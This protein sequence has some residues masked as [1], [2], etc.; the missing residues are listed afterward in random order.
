[1]SLACFFLAPSC[2]RAEQFPSG[3]EDAGKG[4]S[5]FT[6]TIENTKTDFNG[7]KVSWSQDDEIAIFDGV[8]TSLFRVSSIDGGVATFK[9][10]DGEKELGSSASRYTA[11]YPSSSAGE[12]KPIV[13]SEV[14]DETKQL[15]MGAV[16]QNARL[17]FKN[18]CS[19]I[20]FSV[21]SNS[22][23]VGLQSIRLT[24]DKAL[25]GPF[26]I[27]NGAAVMT[28]EAASS[29]AI[30]SSDSGGFPLASSPTVLYVAVPEGEYSVF[31]IEATS[32]N[33][34]KKVFPLMSEG[35]K[36]KRNTIYSK[37]LVLN[38]LDVND[39][40]EE[41]PANCYIATH[42]GKYRFAAVRGDGSA[43]S[44][45]SK[46]KVLWLYNNTNDGPDEGTIISSVSYSDGV[47]DF[48][49]DVME[50]SALLGAVDDSDNIL[51]SW[52]IWRTNSVPAD[53]TYPNAIMMDRYLGALSS[54]PGNIKCVGMMYQY[55]RKDPF[56]GR[57]VAGNTLGTFVGLPYKEEPGPVDLETA[58]RNPNIRYYGTDS[59]FWTTAEARSEAE[60]DGDNKTVQD[61]CPYGYR[62]PSTGIFGTTAKADIQKLFTWDPSSV[63][64]VY[65][66]DD[67]WYPTTGQLAPKGKNLNSGTLI[68]FSWS[69]NYNA[70]GNPL[71]LD[72]R[73]STINGWSGGA[74]AAGFAVR[75]ER[76]AK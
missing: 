57:V 8:Q 73:N 29:M 76:I 4:I 1:M 27:V 38:D 18:I 20:K 60:W 15:P 6:A 26:N 41:G 36:L 52:H 63:G 13:I 54:D 56:P 46:I 70:N 48:T 66:N 40:R 34:V 31:T 75:C 14:G 72:L 21:S 2:D 45:I 33:G 35:L 39:F 9:L 42:K 74:A 71:F 22:D 65:G 24:A 19:L 49:T 25:S 51:W 5:E 16:S 58:T 67:A 44:N 12:L 30:S 59:N 11:W 17:D 61:P 37:S 64:F 23:G 62:V 7:G 53:I 50:G 55:G 69:H 43:I 32:S 10:K 28:G 3:N 68:S 47:V